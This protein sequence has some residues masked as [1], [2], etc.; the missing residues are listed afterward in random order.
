MP[1]SSP[2]GGLLVPDT[3]LPAFLLERAGVFG[4]L[5]ALVDGPTGR[6]VTYAGL[7]T[8]VERCAAGLTA[9]GFGRGDVLA[10]LAPNSPDWPVVLLG[11]QLAGG[12]VTPVNP[13][14]TADEV[15]RQLRSSGARLVVTAAAFVDRVT[16]AGAGD[17]VVLGDAPDGTTPLAALLDTTVPA[18]RM[19]IDPGTDVAF[20]PYSSGTTGLPKGV[21][22]THRNLVA[23]TE[24]ALA[25][26]Q[27]TSRDVLIGTLPFFHA[28]GLMSLATALRAG[29]TVVTLPRFDLEQCLRLV[30]E[31]RATYLP[32]APPM[33]LAL[34]RHPAVDRYD[35]SSLEFVACGA[36][37]L[38][39]ELE[40]EC[41][42]RLG[43]PVVQAYGMTECSAVIAFSRR[44]GAGRTPGGAGTLVPAR[45]RGWSTRAPVRKS[46]R[47][48]PGSCGSEARRS[49]AG[50][51]ATR[52]RRRPRWIPRA[53]CTPATSAR[54]LR[55]AR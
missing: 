18:P 51:W 54:S 8:M 5:P 32:T 45:R 14:W 53:G 55:T 13:L 26:V 37:P 3:G 22:L 50:T 35:L 9:R 17:V 44:D 25:L 2:L 19:P 30:E 33:V 39:P 40:S 47:A 16:A 31:H 11:A 43:R 23:N 21:C 7:Q 46:S 29:S 27:L 41:A 48:A 52:C 49:W 36:A 28:A 38:S 20:L 34:A 42:A 4:D 24:Q 12:V 1:V 15:A 6:A 10:L